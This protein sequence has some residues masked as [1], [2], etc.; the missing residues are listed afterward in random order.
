MRQLFRGQGASRGSALGRA[1]VRLPA[2]LDVVEE[3]IA[4]DAVEP[5]LER[6]HAA[7]AGVRDEMHA[8]RERLHGALAHEVGEFLDLHTLLLDDP[9][10]LQGL[11]ELIRSRRYSAD[12]ALKLQRDRI[13]SVFE[14][15]DDAY[16]RSRVEDIDQVI[17]RVRT[18]LHRR[19]AGVLGR[20]GDILVCDSVAPAELAQLQAQGVMA[21]VATAGSPLS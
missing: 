15:M 8:L 14:A 11:D 18:A 12:Y 1:R 7:I 2:T 13:A 3:H 17:G 20:A 6:L 10:L 4:E 9:E 16:F 19:D 21:I 5:E